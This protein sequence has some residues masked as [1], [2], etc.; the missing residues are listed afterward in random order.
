MIANL[1]SG[2]FLGL[3]ALVGFCFIFGVCY[4]AVAF[5][6]YPAYKRL[7]GQKQLREY[8]RDL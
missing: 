7:G 4:P 3:A 6:V 1:T 2:L 8:M 5:L